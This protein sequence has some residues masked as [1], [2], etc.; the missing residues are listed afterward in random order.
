MSMKSRPPVLRA[1][2]QSAALGT[3][4]LFLVC[5][6]ILF[7]EQVFHSSLKGLKIWWDVVLPALLPF[8]IASEIML[9][10]GMVHFFGVLLEPLMRPL[11]RVPGTGAF[12]MAMAFAS[13]YLVGPKL[14]ARLREQELITRSE[15]ERLVSFANT[16]G[17]LFLFG[18]IAVGFFHDV[19][20]GVT[21]AAAHYSASLIVGLLM[22]FHDPAAPVTETSAVDSR[23][24]LLRAL[25]AMHH[26]RLKDGRSV[27]QLMGD[28]VSSAIQTLLAVGGFIVLF[29]VLMTILGQVGITRMLTAGIGAL[30]TILHLPVELAPSLIAGTLE[31]TLGA[32]SASQAPETVN[33][34]HKLA[35]VS[36]VTA[37]SGL[38]VHAQ[39]ASILSKTDIRYTPYCV[40]RLMHGCLA[41]VITLVIHKPVQQYMAHSNTAIPA[42]FRDAPSGGWAQFWEWTD[43]IGIRFFT[44]IGTLLTISA[45]IHLV[46]YARMKSSP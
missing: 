26:A 7:P 35:V 22:R 13:G 40:A 21:I 10:F 15:G 45:V 14:T 11:F 28:A 19:T 41:A 17:P 8:F 3:V 36:A 5:S 18:A 44:F 46:R 2:L 16:A 39:V 30:F 38:S 6:L 27:G 29:S 24:F 25:Q 1:R 4:S 42:I 20:L 43:F 34:L 37:W 31:V 32:Q 9:G 23:F 33:S 12:V